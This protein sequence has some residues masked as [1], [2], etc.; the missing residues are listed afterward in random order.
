MS[1]PVDER[2]EIVMGGE[3]MK[4]VKELKYLGTVLSQHREME[5]EIRE[6]HER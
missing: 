5:R 2:C 3:R 1:A 6:G 4:V